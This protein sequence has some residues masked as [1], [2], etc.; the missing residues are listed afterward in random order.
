ML[1]LDLLGTGNG[2]GRRQLDCSKEL[3]KRRR[4]GSGIIMQ[5]PDPVVNPAGGI[6]TVRFR[7]AAGRNLGKPCTDGGTE[8]AA[9]GGAYYGGTHRKL[10]L[11]KRRRFIR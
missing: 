3:L 2:H 5:K 10:Q 7:S 1:P 9:P 8:A 11:Q 4:F 6:G